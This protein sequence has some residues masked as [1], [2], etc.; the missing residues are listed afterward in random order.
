MD[1]VWSPS[2]PQRAAK[3]PLLGVWADVGAAAGDGEDQAL[4]AEGLDRPQ[5]GVAADVMLLLELGNTVKP[6]GS[7]ISGGACP[8]ARVSDTHAW[9]LGVWGSREPYGV[10]DLTVRLQILCE[11]LTRCRDSGT[12]KG[13]GHTSCRGKGSA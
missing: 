8:A 10:E 2:G 11:L 6:T 12:P 1:T 5:Y 13:I 7:L 3:R 4:I 9:T